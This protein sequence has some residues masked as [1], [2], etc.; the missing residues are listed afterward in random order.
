MDE[1]K[2]FFSGKNTTV[3]YYFVLLIAIWYAVKSKSG[4]YYVYFS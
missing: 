3:I 4:V 1:K 2:T